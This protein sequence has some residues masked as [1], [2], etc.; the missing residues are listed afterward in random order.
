MAVEA[1]GGPPPRGDGLTLI[2]RPGQG[3]AITRGQGITPR[4][5]G[6]PNKEGPPPRDAKEGDGRPSG[7]EGDKM[8]KWFV[9]TRDKPW[10]P[11]S[12]AEGAERVATK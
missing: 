2:G 8:W 11:A 7:G 12:G 9:G 4:L 1:R 6:E 3:A 5:K 10:D